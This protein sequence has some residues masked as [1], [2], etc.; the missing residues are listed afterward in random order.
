VNA[1]DMQL[2]TP[3]W[4]LVPRE[5]VPPEGENMVCTAAWLT[6]RDPATNQWSL[7][8]FTSPEAV[9]RF[10]QARGL[11]ADT[12]PSLP[13]ERAPM[14]Q[15]LAD[16]CPDGLFLRIDP[17]SDPVVGGNRSATIPDLLAALG[18]FPHDRPG[19][20]RCR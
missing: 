7:L 8:V 20:N 5:H 2:E 15:L 12:F 11:S 18:A 13:L 4:L 9:Q 14:I 19:G 1:S 10:Y 16:L 17:A 6:G 3:L